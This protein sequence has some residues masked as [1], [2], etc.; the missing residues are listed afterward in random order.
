[1]DIAVAAVGCSPASAA[2]MAKRHT[3]CSQPAILRFATDMFMDD[4]LAMLENDPARLVEFIARPET[5]RGPLQR[6][7]PSSQRHCSR[8]Q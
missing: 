4:F 1:M 7:R 2:D 8:A 5:W 3:C 6:L